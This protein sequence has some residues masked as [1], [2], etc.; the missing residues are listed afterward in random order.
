[1]DLYININTVVEP[2]PPTL[3]LCM[4]HILTPPDHQRCRNCILC[5][6]SGHTVT[7]RT[8]SVAFM[9]QVMTRDLQETPF[10]WS[11]INTELKRL[12]SNANVDVCAPCMQWLQRASRFASHESTRYMLLVDQLFMCVLHP[13]RAPGKTACIQ[14]RVYQRILRTLRQ[15]GNPLILLCPILIRDVIATKLQLHHKKPLMHIMQCW[16][17]LNGSPEILPSAEVARAVRFFV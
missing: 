14:A 3:Y 7:F 17:V 10:A 4:V 6:I 9:R 13:G 2:P 11:Y 5:G 12:P 16:W 8:R 1:L 15:P